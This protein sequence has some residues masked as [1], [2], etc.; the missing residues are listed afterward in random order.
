MK[1]CKMQEILKNPGTLPINIQA[2]LK[3]VSM[4]PTTA[5]LDVI[6]EEGYEGTQGAGDHVIAEVGYDGT[7]GAGDHVSPTDY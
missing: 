6:A 7:Q 5:P 3:M 2:S 1:G 4:A